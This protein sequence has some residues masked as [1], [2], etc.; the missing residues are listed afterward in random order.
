VLEQFA[1]SLVGLD[2]TLRIAGATG[3]I[4]GDVLAVVVNEID[5][6][7]R[8]LKVYINYNNA[9][10]EQVFSFGSFSAQSHSA[11]QGTAVARMPKAKAQ[12]KE[13]GEQAAVQAGGS[14]DRRTRIKTIIEAKNEATIKDISEIITDVSEKTIQRE[15]NA[16]I[17]ENIVKRQGERRWSKYSLF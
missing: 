5:V 10:T 8:G 14:E 11:E 2:S 7:L 12:P 17:E 3:V 6:V 1:Q 9:G 4:A 13:A 15:L 16:M